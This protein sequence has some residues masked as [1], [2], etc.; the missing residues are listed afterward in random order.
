ME[1]QYN[2]FYKIENTLNGKFYYGV[3]GTNNLED[4]YFGSGKR[5]K[6]AITK[7]GKENFV[8]ENLL[9]FET[10]KQALDYEVEIVNE[11]LILDPSCYNLKVGGI[12][13]C[14][15]NGK[16]S[17][18]YA[19]RGTDTL[20]KLWNNSDFRERK[21]EFLSNNLKRLHKEGKLK[22][23]NFTGKQHTEEFKI[24]IGKVNAIKQSGSGNSQYGT[25][26]ITNEK[27]N[28]KIHRGDLIPAGWRLGRKIKIY[29]ITK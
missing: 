3:H 28:K 10:Y 11:E 1:K 15:N 25:C 22:Y 26:W 14:K 7:Y 21:I 19:Q 9:F 23:A 4:G 8:K 27:E 13:G 18:W 24:L 29:L 2:Y 12:G 17:E 20:I 6:Y 5:V 16:N